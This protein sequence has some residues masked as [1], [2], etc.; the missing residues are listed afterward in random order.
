MMPAELIAALPEKTRVILTTLDLLIKK[1]APSFAPYFAG[2]ML[3]YGKYRYR[4][5]SGREGESCRIGVAATASGVSIYVACVDEGG[6]LAEQAA[7]SLGRASV[8][9]SCI[10]YKRL[11][12]IDLKGLGKLIQKSHRLKG[13]SEVSMD[14]PPKK[15][16]Y[17]GD[18]LK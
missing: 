12:D 8:G 17:S 2:K 16:P 14:E 5:E 6:W 4:Y 15:R 10:R 7:A 1:N 3:A 18:H 9:K 11:E 13:P